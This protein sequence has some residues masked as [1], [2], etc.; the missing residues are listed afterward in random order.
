MEVPEPLS[1]T[2]LPHQLV[3]DM[4][5]G[6]GLREPRERRVRDPPLSGQAAGGGAS[7]QIAARQELSFLALSSG[8]LLSWAYGSARDGEEGDEASGLEGGPETQAIAKN[9][10]TEDS[11][12]KIAR[13]TRI[14]PGSLRYLESAG[15]GRRSDYSLRGAPHPRGR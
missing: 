15:G 11:C 5:E 10:N 1:D 3:R 9:N 12:A 4:R 13:Q 8:T 14:A 6:P 2:F 7:T